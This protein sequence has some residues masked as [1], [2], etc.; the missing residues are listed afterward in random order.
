MANN[1]ALN[2]RIE[3]A[4]E[5]EKALTEVTK[6]QGRAAIRKGCRAGAKIVQAAAK[7]T[8]PKKTGLLRK[9]I[10]VRAIK[11]TR[12]KIG[13]NVTTG[14]TASLFTGKTYY[15]AFQEWGWKVGKRPGKGS[16]DNRRKIPGK[17]FLKKAATSSAGEVGRVASETIKSE[18]E[19]SMAKNV[20]KKTVKK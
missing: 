11:R 7:Q 8:V 16:A 13:V 14:K 4:R 6:G 5:I 9:S 2:V 3:G 17:F 18:I 1:V 15:G 10:K 12:T 19:K 20:L